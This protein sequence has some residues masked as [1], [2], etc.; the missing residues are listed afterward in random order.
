MV[1]LASRCEISIASWQPEL[2]RRCEVVMHL[3]RG[4]RLREYGERER[5]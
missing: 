5:L 2:Q 4:E 3:E 1:P